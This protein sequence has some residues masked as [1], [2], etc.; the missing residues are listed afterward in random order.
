MYD[1]YKYGVD[2]NGNS[3]ILYKNYDYS[4]AEE[5]KDMSFSLKRDTLGEMWIRLASHPIAF[6]A[7]SG[8]NPMYYTEDPRRINM[9]ILSAAVADDPN[10]IVWADEDH[11]SISMISSDMKVFYDFELSKSKTSIA[12]ATLN[13]DYPL[14]SAYRRF[15]LAWIIGSQIQSYYDQHTDIEW[16]QILNSNGAGVERIDFNYNS[17]VGEPHYIGPDAISAD[18][19]PY[20]ALIGF[21]P[22]DDSNIDFVYLEKMYR[23]SGDVSS[24]Y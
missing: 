19:A 21:Y 9:S 3:Y 18:E 2:I 23:L 8:K 4:R 17:L 20:P 24:A 6:P 1:I 15:D 13:G 14:L 16:L 5:L 12:Y 11:N 10:A 22:V 7:F